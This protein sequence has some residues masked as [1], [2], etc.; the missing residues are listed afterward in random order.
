MRTETKAFT[1][2]LATFVAAG[3]A[4]SAL[5]QGAAPTAAPTAAG[6]GM[7]MEVNYVLLGAAILQ[8]VFI[9]GLSGVMRTLI[10]PSAA[11]MQ[12]LR[13]GGPI[14]VLLPLLLFSTHP[15][16]AQAYAGDTGKLESME[17]FW[18]LVAINIFLF[19]ILMLQLA[20]LRGMTGALSTAVSTETGEAVA[21]EGPT[22]WQ[23]MMRLLTR[24]VE[25]ER[26][27]DVLMHHDYDGI[28]ELD[29]V[30]P[31]WWLWLFYG[32]IIWGVVYLVNLHV[33]NIW[34]D[35]KTLY[36]QEMDQAKTDVAAYMATLTNL[37]DENNVTASTDAAVIASGKGIYTQYCVACHLANGEGNVGPNLTDV[38]WLHGG[39]IK[40]VFKTIKYGVPEK[41]MISWQ[42]QLKPAEIQ[43][44]ASY[45][46]GLQGSNPPNAKAP[47]GDPWT[48]DATASDTAKTA[49]VDSAAIAVD[50]T[51]AGPK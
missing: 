42:S 44:V 22:A 27:Q 2:S 16:Q 38:Y 13:K 9:V 41:G 18:W 8:M 23:R 48:G 49:V 31:P 30:L 29:N 14:A 15:A 50:T 35:Q 10:G 1:R 6:A 39:G 12:R 46:L 32:S 45:I 51:K 19:I 21:V 17:L 7:P 26:E 4:L 25:A 5:A 3:T 28:Q 37:V 47:Q 24:R 36:T 20:L 11:W 34:P 33:I 40:N 43:A